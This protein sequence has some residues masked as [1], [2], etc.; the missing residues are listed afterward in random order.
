MR[1]GNLTRRA[2]AMSDRTTPM[3]RK[4]PVSTP[5][6]KNN[7]AVGICPSGKPA[8]LSPLAKPRP[9]ISPKVK[10]HDP[11]RAGRESRPASAS[12]QD[13]RRDEDDAQR[14]GGL[15]RPLRDVDVAERR[16]A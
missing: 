15:D 2:S 11:R 6:L 12:V 14:D 3:K 7:S 10:R 1:R 9:C 8:S 16:R 13:L 4:C 5:M